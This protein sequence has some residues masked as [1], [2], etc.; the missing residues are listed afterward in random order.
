[1]SCMQKFPEIG[2]LPQ[3]SSELCAALHVVGPPSSFATI[4]IAKTLLAKYG[5]LL[6]KKEAMES[7]DE[8]HHVDNGHDRDERSDNAKVGYIKNGSKGTTRIFE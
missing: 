4:A 2:Q 5:D 1:M 3:L 6:E 8:S 7:V